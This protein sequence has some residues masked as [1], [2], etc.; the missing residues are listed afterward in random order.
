MCGSNQ[1]NVNSFGISVNGNIRTIANGGSGDC[2]LGINHHSATSSWQLSKV[3]IWDKYLSNSDF[4]LASTSLYSGLFSNTRATGVCLPCQANS[5]SQAGASSC[6]CDPGYTAN[7]GWRCTICPVDTFKEFPGNDIPCTA[8]PIN[9]T[10]VAGSAVCVCM[11]GYTG[12]DGGPCAPCPLNTFKSVVGSSSCTPCPQ[13]SISA[14]GSTNCMCGLG[15]MGWPFPVN[16]AR[17]CGPSY[18]Q[19]CGPADATSHFTQWAP[20]RGN[21]ARFN[22]GLNTLGGMRPRFYR[23]DL[24]TPRTIEYVLVYHTNSGIDRAT[25]RVGDNIISTRNAICA[26]FNTS[27]FQNS[28]CGLTGNYISI[29]HP[30]D[31]NAELR[32]MELEVFTTQCQ[33]CPAGKYKNITG[34]DTCT[35][36]PPNMFSLPGSISPAAC[37]GCMPGYFESNTGQCTACPAGTYKSNAGVSACISY[38]CPVGQ[39]SSDMVANTIPTCWTCP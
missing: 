31:T 6:A 24:N 10:S 25:L 3:Y 5:Q 13:N 1:R 8:C 34:P 4:Q 12:P 14:E 17:A 11:T 36:C 7:E 2:A 26:T 32:F 9:S 39:F 19:Q 20:S 38:T 33:Q 30:P 29:V 27:S 15:W 23:L 22:S 18:N 21:D 37:T 28:S 16:V 35:D